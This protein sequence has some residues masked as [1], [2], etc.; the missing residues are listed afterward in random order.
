MYFLPRRARRVF[1]KVAKVFCG[2]GLVWGTKAFHLGGF[3][4]TDD[5]DYT[6]FRG[7]VFGFC[8]GVFYHEGRGGFSRRAR[9]RF[10]WVGVLDRLVGFLHK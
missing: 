3:F 4:Y 2:G 10:T 7:F 1:T 8:G 5:A 9:R 6:D